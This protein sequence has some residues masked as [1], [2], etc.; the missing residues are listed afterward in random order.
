MGRLAE[1]SAVAQ[2]NEVAVGRAYGDME[3]SGFLLPVLA[4]EGG[5]HG[6]QQLCAAALAAV[7]SQAYSA[8]CRLS[9]GLH[10]CLIG[11][12]GV[13]QQ[14]GHQKLHGTE[15]FFSADKPV[16]QRGI[17]LVI[18][19]PQ[20][21][22]HHADAVGRKPQTADRGQQPCPVAA[23]ALVLQLG[24]EGV[25]GLLLLGGER[26][27]NGVCLAQ[28]AVE[29]EEPA[30]QPTETAVH[31]LALYGGKD[32][33]PHGAQ[34]QVIEQEAREE[35]VLGIGY[36]RG[37][38]PGCAAE[39]HRQAG[40]GYLYVFAVFAAVIGNGFV[41]EG[42]AKAVAIVAV[43][44]AEGGGQGI[45]LGFEHQGLT[46]VIVQCLK[47]GGSRAVGG[48]EEHA[49][50]GLLGF[51]GIGRA[52]L[53][54]VLGLDAAVFL[55]FAAVAGAQVGMHHTHQVAAQGEPPLACRGGG[56]DKEV[57]VGVYLP[58]AVDAA[59]PG[60]A[61]RE[62]GERAQQ[63][64]VGVF[65]GKAVAAYFGKQVGQRGVDIVGEH[66]GLCCGL[67]LRASCTGR[68]RRS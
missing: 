63:Q 18:H 20:H 34:G 37:N 45:T 30:A 59:D 53:R 54:G 67:G 10:Q 42:F 24:K 27:A 3:Q 16:G 25:E 55:P 38:L 6:H 21:A 2:L 26:E 56:V 44:A 19:Q 1:L 33:V 5:G 17:A 68:I 11:Q 58:L 14:H 43:L 46:V 4:A 12:G 51:V 9:G 22:E 61:R 15:V 66:G 41:V 48:Q 49:H 62:C 32:I 23:D 64:K 31:G 60:E 28:T 65:R 50:G 40:L 52:A 29:L 47:E 35:A 36:Q 57:E 7:F 13:L 8:V 39:Q